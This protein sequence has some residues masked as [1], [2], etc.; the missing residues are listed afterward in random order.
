VGHQNKITCVR[1]FI[2]EKGVLTGSTDGNLKIWDVS[3]STYRQT[4]NLPSSSPPNCVDIRTDGSSAVSGHRDGGLRFWDVRSGNR[5]F[6]MKRKRLRS[7]CDF[8]L[9]FLL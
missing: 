7:F 4:L 1:L 8:I 5:T 9:E 2:D 6:N 3:R